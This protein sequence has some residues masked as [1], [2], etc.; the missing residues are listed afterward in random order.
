MGLHQKA[1]ASAVRP[2]DPQRG[3]LTQRQISSGDERYMSI[4]EI[5]VITPEGYVEKNKP[6]SQAMKQI[7]RIKIY[8]KKGEGCDGSLPSS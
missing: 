4:C 1:A 8:D 2:P 6:A 3:G 7:G 5:S